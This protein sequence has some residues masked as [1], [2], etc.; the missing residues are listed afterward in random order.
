M[1]ARKLLKNWLYYLVM[2]SPSLV[3]K[4][5]KSLLESSL[6]SAL[7]WLKPTVDF[8]QS[9]KTFLQIFSKEQ[10]MQRGEAVK[11]VWH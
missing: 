6:G 7:L 2:S 9:S 5:F 1:F 8:L 4:V 10:T 11:G 3:F